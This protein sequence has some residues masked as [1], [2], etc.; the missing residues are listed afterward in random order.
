MAEK[1]L[2]DGKVHNQVE[3]APGEFGIC[4]FEHE[5]EKNHL[6]R[7]RH[8]YSASPISTPASTDRSAGS[9]RFCGDE[10]RRYL[11]L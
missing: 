8:G 5:I 7:T 3:V 9:T 2:E 10:Y 6:R 1:R 11:E 4:I